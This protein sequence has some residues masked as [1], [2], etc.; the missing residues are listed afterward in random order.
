MLHVADAGR[1]VGVAMS[2]TRRKP[3]KKRSGFESFERDVVAATVD[4]SV[5]QLRG[6][7]AQQLPTVIGPQWSQVAGTW[8]PDL[9]CGLTELADALALVT[10]APKTAVAWVIAGFAHA[11]G[12]P[13]F[14]AQII[15]RL[16]ANWLFTPFDPVNDA[17]RRIRILG[18]LLCAESGDL[19]DCPCLVELAQQIGVS[20]LKKEIDK[21]LSIAPD[22]AREP[23]PASAGEPVSHP[24]PSERPREGRPPSPTT[25][26]SQERPQQGPA[27]EPGGRARPPDDGNHP[28][29]AP[30]PPWPPGP[31]P[32]WAPP[33][34]P[35]SGPPPGPPYSGP[36]PGPPPEPPPTG[37]PPGPPPWEPPPE[38]PPSGP[39]PE[40]PPF[41]KRTD[42]SE[43]T[44]QG[45][46]VGSTGRP[47][48]ISQSGLIAIKRACVVARGD[49]TP[50]VNLIFG[51]TR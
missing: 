19:G 45:D 47:A 10:N 7:A 28:P 33:E 35:Q 9:C 44:G 6:A 42:P 24:T 40:P 36:P 17:V 34:P 50:P 26:R 32:P 4:V 49:K 14:I 51:D 20:E 12:C 38:S 16:V 21:G 25:P 46:V 48:A 31:R 13:P 37:P 8:N 3:Y 30:R 29:D 11:M 23:A 2:T 27:H 1:E 43:P 39:S 18:V 41:A 15:G 5:A 22:T